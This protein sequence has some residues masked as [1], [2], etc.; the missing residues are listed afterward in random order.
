MEDV[1]SRSSVEVQTL[2]RQNAEAKARIIELAMSIGDEDG[3]VQSMCDMLHS[4]ITP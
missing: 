4:A 1:A 2:Q 3:T